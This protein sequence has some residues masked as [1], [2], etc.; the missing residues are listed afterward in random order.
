MEMNF[1]TIG[2]FALNIPGAG[3]YQ[4]WTAVSVSIK[5]AFPLVV[6]I[7]SISV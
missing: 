6:Y 7:R 4:F 1:S 3:F 2:N 5:L